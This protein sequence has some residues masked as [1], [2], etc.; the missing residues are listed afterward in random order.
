MLDEYHNLLSGKWVI[1][2]LPGASLRISPGDRR[3]KDYDPG[4]F[5]GSSMRDMGL[6]G[7][8]LAAT[9][10]P[11][12][13]QER[14]RTASS[15]GSATLDECVAAETPDRLQGVT[16]QGDL[17]LEGGR[18]AKLASI[19]LPDDRTGRSEALG[20]LEART[21]LSVMIR[22][23]P[24]PDRWNRLPAHIRLTEGDDPADLALGLVAAGLALVDPQADRAFCR[25]DL[26]TFEATARAQS[27]GL[28]KDG[29]YNPLD[30][31]QADRLRERI[32]TF[33]L[34]EGHVR[35]VG[36]RRQRTYLNFGGHWAEDFTIIVPG[37]TWKLMAE[38]GLGAAALKGRRIRAR[39]IL[40]SWQGTALTVQVP[41]M[42]ERL[43][44]ERLPR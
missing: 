9:V 21:G 1:G 44:G 40:E 27:L 28:W 26:L 43:A 36:E 3:L 19:R 24:A 42:I 33:V 12:L 13:G 18:L 34:V 39:G 2:P 15:A 31:G 20:W 29:R 25:P 23:G 7:L 8:I 41:E 11:A 32:G 30:V 5:W 37:R 10:V 22:A 17:I 4:M 14:E 38:R 35:T 16:Q 6:L